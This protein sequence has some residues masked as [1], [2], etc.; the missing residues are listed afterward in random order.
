V[1]PAGSKPDEPSA[2]RAKPVEPDA[3]G[4]GPAA[5]GGPRIVSL[6][7][8]D[9]YKVRWSRETVARDIVQNFFDE[10]EDFGE[11]RVEVDE[12]AG[13][14]RVSG[15]SRFDLDYLRYL[16]ATTKSEP[17]ARKAGGFGEGF[18]ICALVLLR[19]F[20]VDVRAGSGSWVIRPFLAPMDLGRELRYEV[21]EVAGEDVCPGSFVELTGV[22][23]ALAGIFA[24]VKDLFRHPGNPRLARPIHVDAAAG[25]GGL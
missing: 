10:V 1:T 8:L 17:V 23:R 2:P 16:G 25:V 5:A 15:P 7:I 6:A 22:D 18:K 20:H 19:D 12:A 11:V 3:A 13:R 21:R 4:T 9:G 14:V 24:T